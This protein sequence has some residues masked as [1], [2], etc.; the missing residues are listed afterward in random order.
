MGL[1]EFAL[2]NGM[3]PVW[4]CATVVEGKRF[5]GEI[6]SCFWYLVLTSLEVLGWC[7]S[8]S[9]RGVVFVCVNRRGAVPA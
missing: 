9:Q 8:D 6:D 5:D 4:V 7:F 1:V 2:S 3:A